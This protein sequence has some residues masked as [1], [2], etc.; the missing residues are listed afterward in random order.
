VFGTLL[1]SWRIE[2]MRA[3]VAVCTLSV[4]V[5]APA[6]AA[7]FGF[8]RMVA[9]GLWENLVQIVA[10]GAAG[11]FAIFLFTR[12]VTLLGG[13]RGGVFAALV[14]GFAL[15]I[16]LVTIG[17]VPSAMQLAGFAVVMVG[18]RFVLKP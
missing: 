5:Y 7:L 12:A 1:R 6:H 15:A 9:V 13:G 18:F 17:E 14:P 3:A 4:L 10:Q 16:G 11:A 2:G 8:D